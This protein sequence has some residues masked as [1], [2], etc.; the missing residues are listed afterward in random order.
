MAEDDI[1]QMDVDPSDHICPYCRRTFSSKIGLGVHKRSQHHEQYNREIVTAG[2][3]PRWAEEE[4]RLLAL[5]EAHA[6]DGTKT[7]NVY[8]KSRFVQSRSLE[9]IKGIRKRQDYKDLVIEYKNQRVVQAM[10]DMPCSPEA[11]E[12]PQFTEDDRR[13]VTYRRVESGSLTAREWL[14]ANYGEIIPEMHGGIWI[15]T[16][17]RR[18]VEGLP[19][20]DCMDQ[21][22]AQVF[23]DLE[24]SYRAR[25]AR[26]PLVRR[27]LS[28]RKARRREYRRMQALWR[29]NMSKA[30]HKVL[31]GDAD[32]VP[33]PSLADQVKYWKP[34]LE[35]RELEADGDARPIGDEMRVLQSVWDPITVAEV[36]TVK[37][38]A[39]SAPGLDGLTVGRWMSEVPA[40]LRAAILNIIMA[41]G[42]M[43]RRFRDSRTVLIPKA[44]DLLE[45][46]NYR[47]ISVASVV[48]RHFHKIL[49]KRLSSHRIFDNRQRG[50]IAADGCAENISILSAL[51]FDARS[52]RRQVHVV[53]LDVKKAFDTVSHRGV[54]RVLAGCGLPT[55]MVEYIR[56]LY[57]SATLRIEV[58]RAFSDEIHPGRGVRQGDPLSPLIFNLVMNDVLAAVPNQVGYVMGTM[59]INALAFADDLIVVGST[60]E[61]AQL[62]LGRVG[63]ALARY[64]LELSPAKCAAF[65]LVPA[66]KVKKMK[67][68]TEPQFRIGDQLVTQAGML[69]KIKY[70][71][72]WFADD[73]PEYS[74]RDMTLW[75]E[76]IRR[77]P[78]KPQQRLR[79][80]KMFL[81]PRFI[82]GLVL[83]RA[84]YN[85]LRKV[86]R[87]VRAEVRRWLY[88]P[89]DTTNAFFHSPV[90]KGGL[91]I[92][93]LE[94]ATP[95]LTWDRLESLRRSDYDLA[96]M[97]G[98]SAW[99]ER[100]RKWCKM[101]KRKDSDWPVEL[102]K[103]VDGFELREAGAVVASTS[104]IEDPMVSIPPA[105][106]LHYMKVWVNALPTRI[107]TTRGIRRARQDVG[108]R[109]GCDEIETAAHVIQRCFRTHGGR[110]MRHDA[111]AARVAAELQRGEHTTRREKIFRTEEGVR[112]PD[113]IVSKGNRG[114]VLDV[115][116]ISGSRPLS[117]GHRRK[118]DY[119]SSNGEL[120]GAVARLLQI[121]Q[122]K[123]E[124]STVTLSWR[125]V[126]AS[127]SAAVLEK[128]GL[129]RA[130]MRGITTRVLQGS[131]MNFRRFNQMTAM[132][133][134]RRNMMMSGWG[135]PRT[136]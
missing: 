114:H 39:K 1:A 135:P 14:A 2:V 105:D 34:I 131:Y 85:E 122:E 133:R 13:E 20:D 3:K 82:H 107:R 104:W 42:R 30:A 111:V 95:R 113:L 73:G 87:Q 101:G 84:T 72:I 92:M 70:L 27:T 37:L 50:F 38:P 83:G 136:H 57:E 90:R 58:D 117:E 22:W 6:P 124:V 103:A 23:P 74:V 35:A 100:R 94:S 125:G 97:A 134:G 21:W 64:G 89:G 67:V 127:E 33:H 80:L 132:Y 62:A 19:P 115:Q 36:V 65:S 128:L 8:L 28:A 26:D 43:P 121:P 75:L 81:L 98:Q 118:R 109:A 110:V 32:G 45:P 10:D 63:E 91:G 9:A 41:T 54:C 5:E 99:A 12:E 123:I 31:D 78:L 25:G 53:T 47:P 16:A 106:W 51:I 68:I 18:V 24:A 15:R 76:K 112:K 40:I 52:N 108:C 86:D 129:S 102:Y 119:Y 29:K 55:G 116:I 96:R 69:R 77:A 79:V 130:V 44:P 88:L 56:S 71:G 60:R 17:A 4:V 46:A 49:A 48:L 59:N 120:M 61:G 126:W 93:S 7:M 11:V 66:G